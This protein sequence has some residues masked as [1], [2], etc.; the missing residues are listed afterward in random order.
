MADG[1]DGWSLVGATDGV[2]L[3]GGAVVVVCVGVPDGA[4][5]AGCV[6]VAEGFA[7]V[8]RLAAADV[9][10]RGTIDVLAGTLEPPLQQLVETH[11]SELTGEIRDDDAWEVERRKP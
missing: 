4:E 6:G 10:D 7:V 9:A 3:V 2:A 5:V 11:L 1:V 8:C